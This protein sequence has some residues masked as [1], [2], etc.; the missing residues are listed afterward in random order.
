MSTVFIGQETADDKSFWS[1][2]EDKWELNDLAQ[3]RKLILLACICAYTTK[4]TKSWMCLRLQGSV[5]AWSQDALVADI[6]DCAERLVMEQMGTGISSST[7]QRQKVTS[8][9][10]RGGG[11]K[12]EKLVWTSCEPRDNRQYWMWFRH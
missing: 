2:K 4:L 11:W 12:L 9:L 7:S 5:Y 8:P 3:Q 6:D 1:W 10:Q